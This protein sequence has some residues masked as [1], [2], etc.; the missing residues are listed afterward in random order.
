MKCAWRAYSDIARQVDGE[1][2]GAEDVQ[3]LRPVRQQIARSSCPDEGALARLAHPKV[4]RIQHAKANLHPPSSALHDWSDR[5]S[6]GLLLLSS[7][8]D[9]SRFRTQRVS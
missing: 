8:W 2:R 3:Q 1:L 6:G 7:H 4:A 9:C 5:L